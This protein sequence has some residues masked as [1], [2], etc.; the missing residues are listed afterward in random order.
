[1]HKKLI[2]KVKDIYQAGVSYKPENKAAYKKASL[3]LLRSV[4][5]NTKLSGKATF[6]AGG[7]AVLGD[8]RLQSDNLYVGIHE[9]NGELQ[10][11]YRTVSGRTCG[12]NHWA[13]IDK[14]SNDNFLS[15]LKKMDMGSAKMAA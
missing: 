15:S 13:G 8:A 4:A 1:M 5:K 12:P 3:A 9:I 14:L 10:I 11:M 6:N 7:I 2:D